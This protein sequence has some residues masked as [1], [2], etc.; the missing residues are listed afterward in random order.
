MFEI[1]I[2]QDI[3]KL[4]FPIRSDKDVDFIGA[5]VQN[6]KEDANLT[7]L[8]MNKVFIKGISLQSKEARDY[9]VSYWSKDTFEDTDLDVDTF[10]DW[11]RFN[12]AGTSGIDVMRIAGANQ[13]YGSVT[14]LN[15][16]YEDKDASNE[17]HI[18]LLNLSASAKTAG[19]AGEVVVEV[20]VEPRYD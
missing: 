20:W 8:P 3:S 9:L 5:I 15:I 13:F 12:L 17:L 2:S 19:A 16:P 10:I 14:G 18:S 6:A 11:T 1:G 7:G 4:L